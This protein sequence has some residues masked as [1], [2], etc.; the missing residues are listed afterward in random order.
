MGNGRDFYANLYEQDLDRQA[1]WLAQGAKAKADSVEQLAGRGVATVLEVGCG[2]GAVISELRRRGVG[3]RHFGVDYSTDALTVLRRTD[4]AVVTSAADITETP[5]PFGEGPYDLVVAS[6]VIE[7]LEEP[8][9]FLAGLREIPHR[10]AVLEVPLDDLIAHRVKARIGER[11]NDAGHVQ[12]F[13]PRTFRRLVEG[14]G[15]TIQAVRHYAPHVTADGAELAFGQTSRPRH[16][17]RMMVHSYLPRLTEPVWKRWFH[18]H[19]AVVVSH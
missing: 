12:F 4:P 9:R 18:G 2:S 15:F 6:H 10:Q 14:C 16:F 7:H 1:R 8:E 19:Y 5:D 13:T 3:T 17:A 11:R